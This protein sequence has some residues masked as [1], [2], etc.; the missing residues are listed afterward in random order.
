MYYAPLHFVTLQQAVT[1]L[2]VSAF[3]ADAPTTEKF[4]TFGEHCRALSG[5]SAGGEAALKDL[6]K[7]LARLKKESKKG[8]AAPAVLPR[9]PM[10]GG[11][12]RP[13]G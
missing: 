6:K 1:L 2:C 11:I 10:G 13:G 5:G 9:P 4:L 7:E 12:G 3:S 8:A